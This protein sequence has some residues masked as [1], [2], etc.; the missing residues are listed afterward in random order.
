[1]VERR[2]EGRWVLPSAPNEWGERVCLGENLMQRGGAPYRVGSSGLRRCPTAEPH[3]AGLDHVM[4]SSL[5]RLTCGWRTAALSPR[6]RG[7][8][9]LSLLDRMRY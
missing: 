5:A 9:K 1:M 3:A 2:T 4:A 6:G 7:L 8:T